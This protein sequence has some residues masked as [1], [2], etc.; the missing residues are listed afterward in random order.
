MNQVSGRTWGRIGRTPLVSQ[1]GKRKKMTAVGSISPQGHFYFRTYTK[2][3]MTSKR[4]I[5]YLKVLKRTTK[6][7]IWVMHDG[8]SAHKSKLTKSFLE[9][10]KRIHCFLIPSYS[11]ELNPIEWLWARWKKQIGKRTH[12]SEEG[13]CQSGFRELRGIQKKKKYLI[14]LFEH[15]YC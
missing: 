9:K 15:V 11:P 10:E 1:S 13:L 3:G 14:S 8:L 7:Q 4:Y 6:R 5:E 2:G 12:Y